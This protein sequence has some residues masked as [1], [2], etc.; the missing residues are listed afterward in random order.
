MS[1]LPTTLVNPECVRE[2]FILLLYEVPNARELS[3]GHRKINSTIPT[4]CHTFQA[5][6]LHHLV[7]AGSSEPP[8]SSVDPSKPHAHCMSGSHQNGLSPTL[9][10]Q[11]SARLD[12][13]NSVPQRLRYSH[14]ALRGKTAHVVNLV[15]LRNAVRSG[16]AYVGGCRPHALSCQFVSNANNRI[17]LAQGM[18]YTSAATVHAQW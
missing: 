1:R 12:G 15:R 16:A 6:Q 17:Y 13:R 9:S 10:I 18:P 7:T 14:I 8:D 4:S 2:S 11:V 3:Q 5:C